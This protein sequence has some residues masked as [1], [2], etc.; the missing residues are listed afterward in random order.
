MSLGHPLLDL[1]LKARKAVETARHEFENLYA[2]ID[3]E[4]T[5]SKVLSM[6]QVLTQ[7]SQSLQVLSSSSAAMDDENVRNVLLASK[8]VFRDGRMREMT[9]WAMLLEDMSA[10]TQ[11]LKVA[12]SGT[13]DALSHTH[14]VDLRSAQLMDTMLQGYDATVRAMV[15]LHEL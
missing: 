8:E 1:V 3:R 4:S 2:V 15:D 14:P 13:T 9:C 12:K 11:W 6:G 10:I 5:P 7:L